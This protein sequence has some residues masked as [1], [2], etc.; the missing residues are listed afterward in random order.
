ML[1]AG[2]GCDG[3]INARH[4][5]P[6]NK[7][8][9]KHSWP[10]SAP[11]FD[12]CR[13]G[14]RETS[15]ESLKDLCFLG[16]SSAPSRVRAECRIVFLGVEASRLQNPSMNHHRFVDGVQ[17]PGTHEAGSRDHTPTNWGLSK[18][19]GGGTRLADWTP[20][21]ERVTTVLTGERFGFVALLLPVAR[22]RS[23]P[24]GRRGRLDDGERPFLNSPGRG[25]QGGEAPSHPQNLVDPSLF[26][27]VLNHEVRKAKRLGYG[28][29]LLCLSSDVSPAEEDPALVTRVAE[30]TLAVLRGTDLGTTF[31]SRSIGVLLLDAPL[32]T[33]TTILRRIT[34][35]LS[36]L[37]S[38]TGRPGLTVSAGGSCYP[39]TAPSSTELVQQALDLMTIAK[40]DGGN[41]F[42]LPR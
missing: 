11:S 42:Y 23:G 31:T 7:P 20:H 29:S 27:L 40:K 33:L 2:A 3:N 35:A 12:P 13:R 16:K 24:V 6:L 8:E 39:R 9:T 4:G 32:Q 5:L 17:D 26:T 14:P 21:R 37:P 34:D 36:G 19:R 41:R 15:G 38:P 10:A 22:C 25:E 1:D 28:L 18:A 30:A